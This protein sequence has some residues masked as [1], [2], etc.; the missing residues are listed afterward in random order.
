MKAII[1]IPTVLAKMREREDSQAFRL[2]NGY[3]GLLVNQFSCN[4][5]MYAA[6][7][8]VAG[9]KCD[10]FHELGRC[11]QS[12]NFLQFCPDFSTMW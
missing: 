12:I 3:R 1:N 7:D 8:A 5:D 6:I 2:S 10:F 11:F 9:Q 4:Q